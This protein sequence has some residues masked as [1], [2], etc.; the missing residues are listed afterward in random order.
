L[1]LC[2]TV[3]LDQLSLPLVETLF[4]SPLPDVEELQLPLMQVT[5]AEFFL[6]SASWI[7]RS[8]TDRIPKART[9][10][11]NPAITRLLSFLVNEYIMRWGINYTF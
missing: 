2:F 8:M 4:W 10:I 3:T 7:F 6:A 11:V 1:L 5:L 9:V